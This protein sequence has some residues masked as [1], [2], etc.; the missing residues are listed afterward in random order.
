M[1]E[2]TVMDLVTQTKASI[3]EFKK[4]AATKAELD[5]KIGKLT[6]KVDEIEKAW[7]DDVQ[8]KTASG[9][10]SGAAKKMVDLGIDSVAKLNAQH[11]KHVCFYEK[12]LRG[13]LRPRLAVDPD[14]KAAFE[15][16]DEVHIVDRLMAYKYGDLKLAKLK[17]Q[18]GGEKAFYLERF[19]GH[20]LFERWDR[21]TRD[22]AQVT[23]KALTSTG[24]GT[25]DEWVPTGMASN[26]L[27]QIR[28]A[29]P[30]V[31]LFPVVQMPTNPFDYPIR[32]TPG[33]AYIRSENTAV[34]EGTL[35]TAKR[36]LTAYTFANYQ[37]FSDE[38][39]EDAIIAVA[40][41]IRSDLIRALGEGLEESL[42]NGDSDGA[43]HFDEDYDT[44]SAGARTFNSSFS[45]LRRFAIV[46]GGG[47]NSVVAG[48]GTFLT[49]ATVASAL[50]AMGKFGAQRTA[51]LA[52]LLNAES[53]LKLLTEANSPILT[54]D[55]YG[56]S[57]TILTGEL[58]RIYG[59]PIFVSFG[60]EQRRNAVTTAGNNTTAGPNTLS[61]A[62]L[63]NRMNFRLGDRRDVRVETDKDIT[64]G[65]NMVVG[66]ARWGF[67]A[68][69][70]NAATPNAMPAVVAI[71]NID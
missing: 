35:A 25:G 24:V 9:E 45:G 56:P 15:L 70:Q 2:P 65:K 41:E 63:L 37:A 17:A 50:A 53:W 39:S 57:A 14:V 49:A 48:G 22:L 29:V 4:G 3:E 64:S 13:E 30:T 19:K 33:R 59:V 8:R 44:A 55:K 6:G 43:N 27:D 16:A 46:D 28:L 34:T 54:V 42:V 61:T 60:V 58:S 69:E 62:V 10:V 20:A 12:G 47:N 71:V 52:L 66:T 51:D 18:A 38:A 5:E 11:L 26:L 40:G 21:F 68:L 32:S 36:T 67:M 7:K 23:G 31:N 1:P